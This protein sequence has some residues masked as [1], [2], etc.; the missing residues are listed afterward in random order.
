MKQF[1]SNECSACRGRGEYTEDIIQGWPVHYT[2][3]FCEGTGIRQ[4]QPIKTFLFKGGS[5]NGQ[6]HEVEDVNEVVYEGEKNC[7][8][9][10][11]KRSDTDFEYCRSFNNLE[12]F[13]E[14]ILYYI[15]TTP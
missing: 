14:T 13:N 7:F 8:E 5:L 11:E 2:C 6:F 12:S 1:D 3:L 4:K 15:I 10:Y 9:W